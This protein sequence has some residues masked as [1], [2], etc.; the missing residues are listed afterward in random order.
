MSSNK[1]NA[2]SWLDPLTTNEALQEQYKLLE[3]QLSI[4]SRQSRPNQTAILNIQS[5]LKIVK[6]LLNERGL[7]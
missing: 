7:V 4:L 2:S 5:G 3:E 6:G 1:I